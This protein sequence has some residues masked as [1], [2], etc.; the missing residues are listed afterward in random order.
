VGSAT[1]LRPDGT[2][3][4]SARR[5]SL[6]ADRGI[7]QLYQGSQRDRFVIS[8]AREALASWMRRTLR[9]TPRPR[10]RPRKD[11]LG[12]AQADDTRCSSLQGAVIVSIQSP[13]GERRINRQLD[14]K[15]PS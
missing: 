4:V 5:I 11:P 13:V 12:L 10:P 6:A 14:P 3:Q 1:T 2:I 15:A 8:L 9:S 7:R